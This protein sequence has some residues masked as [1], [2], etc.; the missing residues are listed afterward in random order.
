MTQY[1]DDKGKQHEISEDG[2]AKAVLY[3][4]EIQK[5][6]GKANCERID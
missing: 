6:E 4:L 3:K 2:L 1:T 5:E